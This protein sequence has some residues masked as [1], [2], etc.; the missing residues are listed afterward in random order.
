MDEALHGADVLAILTEWD[1]FR[2]LDPVHAQS[3]MRGNVIVDL[4]YLLNK[5]LFCNKG[6]SVLAFGN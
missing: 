4:R 2:G 1:E 6:F 3:L 5:E